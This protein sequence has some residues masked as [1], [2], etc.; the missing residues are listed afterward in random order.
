MLLKSFTLLL[1][2]LG[3]LALG[4]PGEKHDKRVALQEA[5]MRHAFA[6]VNF[7]ALSKCGSASEVQERKERAMKRRLATFH[8]LRAERGITDGKQP[9]SLIH[10]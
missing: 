5:N 7:Q 2:A 4:H 3:E 1:A 10:I 6:D 8:R 9:L